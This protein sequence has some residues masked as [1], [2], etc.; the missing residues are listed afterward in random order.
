MLGVKALARA[1]GNGLAAAKDIE[2]PVR[3]CIC[4]GSAAVLPCIKPCDEADT[5]FR[6]AAARDCCAMEL[7]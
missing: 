7:P 3:P 1:V 5:V 2:P 4:G 6:L